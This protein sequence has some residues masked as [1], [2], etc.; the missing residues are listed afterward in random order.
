MIN[1]NWFFASV[2]HSFGDPY[3]SLGCIAFASV[4]NGRVRLM[5]VSGRYTISLGIE[6]AKVFLTSNR[7]K[8]GKVVYFSDQEHVE[9]NWQI[10]AGLVE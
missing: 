10:A 9:E 1:S 2:K 7:D 8:S 4:A 5:T 6:E 3:F